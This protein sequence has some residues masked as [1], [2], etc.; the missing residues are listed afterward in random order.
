MVKNNKNSLVIFLFVVLLQF[1]PLQNAFS[2]QLLKDL[3]FEEGTWVMVAVSLHNYKLHPYQ[4]KFGTFVMKNQEN[5]KQM[6]EEW[7][8]DMM[9]EDYCDYHYAIKFYK[10]GK[11][12]ETFLI[13]LNCNYITKGKLAYHFTPN[14]LF[15]FS[16]DFQRVSWSRV[17]YKNIQDIQKSV[18]KLVKATDV[19]LYNDFK[20]YDYSGWFV[21]HKDDLY[22]N[23]DK[24][25]LENAVAEEIYQNTGIKNFYI[26]QY[27]YYL[28]EKFKLKMFY[29]VYSEEALFKKYTLNNVTGAWRKH[30]EDRGYIQLV[31]VG[32][33]KKQFYK[34]I[35]E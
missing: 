19:Y 10:D 11:L 31:V 3:D 35:N 30:E 5:M 18:K 29:Y 9:F 15:K 34:I 12:K 4:E 33:G 22:W 2:K 17:R 25:S 27:M 21:I 20:P 1:I 26:K 16:N 32:V 28:D 24:D 14:D 8:F 6:K 13:N 23:P 7:S